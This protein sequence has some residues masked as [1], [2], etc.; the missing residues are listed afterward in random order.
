MKNIL[1]IL[2]LI[3]TSSIS[4][5]QKDSIP[6]DLIEDKNLDQE[7]TYIEVEVMPFYP[8]GETAMFDYLKNKLEYPEAAKEEKIEGRVYVSFIVDKEGNIKDV[9]VLRGLGYGCD[10]EA[11][12]LVK[13]MPKWEAGKRSGKPVDVQYRI[14]IEFSYKKDKKKKKGK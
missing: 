2:S 1:F 5:A 8:G 4:L 10:E 11:A 14:P 9:K 13:N 7:G 12:R 6:S 3:F